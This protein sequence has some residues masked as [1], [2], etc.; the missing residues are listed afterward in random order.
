MNIDVDI[1]LNDENF[2][3]RQKFDVIIRKMISFIIVRDLNIIQHEN[4]R[5]VILFIYFF[6]TTND[7]VFVKIF[8]EKKVHLIKN[9]KTNMLI[10]NDIIV[11]KRIFVDIINRITNIRSCDVI[12][13]LNVCFK[14]VHAQQ[15]FI[16]VKKIIVLSSRTQ[17]IVVVHDFFDDLFFDRDFLFEF[18]DNELIFYAHFVDFFIKV[19]LITNNTNQTIKISRNYRLKKLVKFDYFHVF[20]IQKKRR[21]INYTYFSTKTQIFLIQKDNIRF[22]RRCCRN[23]SC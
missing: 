23:C 8:I 11:S 17:L 20:Q 2:V 7:D 15:R 16:H 18:D 4:S 21:R 22:R 19:I 1:I 3:K 12:V 6:D 10:E 13:S 9:F 5:Y 14:A